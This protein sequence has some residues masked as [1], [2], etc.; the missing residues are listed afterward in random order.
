MNLSGHY[1]VYGGRSSEQFGLRILNLNTDRLTALSSEIEYK[2]SFSRGLKRFKIK[3]IDYSK[4]PLSFDVEFIS[5]EPIDPYVASEA[6]RWLFNKAQPQ[7][8]YCDP[9]YDDTLSRVGT[10]IKREYLNFFF[11]FGC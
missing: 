1:F 3:G 2:T 10:Q 8:L 11:S 9:Q 4:D 6:K 7:K 5:D